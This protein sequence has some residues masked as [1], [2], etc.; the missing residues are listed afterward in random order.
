MTEEPSKAKTGTREW[1]EHSINCCVGCSHNCVY[2]YARLDA[3]RFGRIKRASDW[4]HERPVSIEVASTAT[5]YGTRY[6]GVVMFPT[7]HDITPGNKEV[8]L[9]VLGRLLRAGNRVLVVTKP[10]LAIMPEIVNVANAAI[11]DAGECAT[12]QRYYDDTVGRSFSASVPRS[13]IEVRCSVTCDDSVRRIWEPGT[14]SLGERIECLKFLKASGIATSVSI[15]PNLQPERVHRIVNL[16]GP[17]T[18]GEIWVGKCNKVRE[19]TKWAFDPMH[20]LRKTDQL[21]LR[22]GSSWLDRCQTDETVTIVVRRLE[23]GPFA[24]KIRWK[25][26]YRDVIDRHRAAVPTGRQAETPQ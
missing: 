22:A 13:S 14:P 19:R 7:C 16:V 12:G 3:R 18:T 24:E 11:W 6:P 10:H 26:S 15:E 1:S 8:C 5:V 21:T 17:F 4:G 23:S 2:C 9:I 20:G 25:H